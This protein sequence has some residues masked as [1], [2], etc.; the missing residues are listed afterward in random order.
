M[1]SRDQECRFDKVLDWRSSDSDSGSP[2]RGLSSVKLLDALRAL[3]GAIDPEEFKLREEI[4]AEEARQKEAA[5]EAVRRAWEADR[6]R[7]R[8]ISELELNPDELLPGRLAVEPLRQAAKARLAGLAR[9]TPDKDIANLPALRARAETAKQYAESLALER[10]RTEALIPEIESLIRRL[11]GERP[12]ASV[13]A[14]DAEN[15]LCPVCDVPIDRALAEGCKLSHKLPDLD[16]AKHRMDKLNEDIATEN[17]RLLASKSSLDTLTRQLKP[18]R[19]EADELSRRIHAL[20]QAQE[21]RSDA[22]FKTRRLIHDADCLEEYLLSQECVALVA[23]SL[24]AEI[25]TKRELAA[26]FRGEQAQV[27]SRISK[28]FDAVIRE[29]VGPTAGGKVSLDGNG[30]KLSVELGGDRSTAAI[31]SLK[32][33]AFDLAAMCMSIEGGTHLP[34]FLVHDSPREAD[35]GLSV[36]HRLFHLVRGLEGEE[37]QPLFQYIVTT[38]TRP[39]DEL[40]EAPWLREKLGGA[41]AEGRL[42]RRNL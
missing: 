23:E 37:A 16:A 41:P 1:L 36:Y 2:A 40:S 22:W 39:P 7:L 25:E 42:L 6:L 11:Q 32:V 27:F 10:A 3:I 30:L 5:Q 38:T 4:V 31:D 20:E 18:A 19:S 14:D 24:I 13:A 12:S 29:L 28:F 9:V 21:A 26:A 35:L 33:I 8:L 15:P 34:A 17:G